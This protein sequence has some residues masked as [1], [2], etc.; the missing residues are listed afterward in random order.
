[1]VSL[2]TRETERHSSIYHNSVA[3]SES[4]RY[5][6]VL[7]T[8][9]EL[10][11]DEAFFAVRVSSIHSRWRNLHGD[12]R[13]QNMPVNGEDIYLINF[14]RARDQASIKARED[15]MVNLRR[16]LVVNPTAPDG[17]QV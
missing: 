6:I 2:F 13:P 16:L 11:S 8:I 5:V 17:R 15:E 4:E 12:I 14:D 10:A 7:K 9:C 3:V 1:M